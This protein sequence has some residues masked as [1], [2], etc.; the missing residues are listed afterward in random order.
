MLST[1][2][3]TSRKALG[4]HGLKSVRFR[5]AAKTVL[6]RAE[7]HC[8]QFAT[9]RVRNDAEPKWRCYASDSGDSMTGA[10]AMPRSDIAQ[11]SGDWLRKAP[12]EGGPALAFS[13]IA[14]AIPTLIRLT[15]FTGMSDFQCITFCPFVLATAIAAGWRFAIA[16]AIASA[17]I[18]NTL[19]G[20]PYTFRWDEPELVGMALFLAY[21]SLVIVLVHLVRK[22]SERHG[23]STANPSG[24]VVFSLEAGEAWASWRGTDAPVR[25]G[26]KEEVAFMMQDFLAQ[27][28]LGKRLENRCARR[29]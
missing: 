15:V 18:C 21:C 7:L 11:F 5:R 17:A 23:G 9:I 3:P 26:S 28:E 20:A 4:L 12:L 10:V 29:I 27:L 6:P 22:Q 8:W 13:L 25:L 24:G 16:V 1:R 2:F 19:M 14:V